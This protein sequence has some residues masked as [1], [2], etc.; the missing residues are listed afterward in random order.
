[1]KAFAFIALA[2]C[3]ISLNAVQTQKFRAARG[4]VSSRLNE[5][6][7]T[8]FGKKLL[9]TIAL[10]LKTNQNVDNVIQLLKDLKSNITAQQTVEDADFQTLSTRYQGIIDTMTQ[11]IADSEAEIQKLEARNVVLRAL[12]AQLKIDRAILVEEQGE[13]EKAR[14][15]LTALRVQERADY[16]TRKSEQE[17]MVEGLEAVI[18]L[19]NEELTNQEE[20]NFENYSR[21]KLTNLISKLREINTAVEASLASEEAAEVEAEARYQ[22][23][24]KETAER[25]VEI[26]EEITKIDN[27]IAEAEAEFAENVKAIDIEKKKIVEY[28]AIRAENQKLLQTLI[29]T[30][31][32]NK[33]A[34]AEEVSL[35]DEVI[36]ILSTRLENVRKYLDT[37][38]EVTTAEAF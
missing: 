1:M 14:E 15:D 26:V 12:I 25:L 37:T 23:F 8:P 30:Y 19:L 35:C 36:A 5:I 3:L 4:S 38:P 27:Q 2:L 28:K 31:N 20:I 6:S 13:I 18:Q 7:Q 21:E 33:Q 32:A 16:T 11:N 10:Q 24:M 9:G 22:Q 34:R 29:A 17:A